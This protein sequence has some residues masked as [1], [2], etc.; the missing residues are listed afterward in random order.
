MRKL[1]LMLALLPMMAIAGNVKSPNGNIELKFSINQEG[2]PVYEMTYKDDQLNGPYTY[3]WEESGKMSRKGVYKNNLRNGKWNEYAQNGKILNSGKYVNDKKEGV[4]VFY[5][6][7]EKK[8]REQNFVHDVPEGKFTEYYDN[9]AKHF[10]GNFKDRL[11]DGKW[12]CWRPDGKLFYSAQFS[13]G[14]KVKELFVAD[15]KE[16]RPF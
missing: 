2:R 1:L 12:S 16:G 10:Q 3:Y 7:H 14:H 11:R 15:P 13:R 5:N 8:I 6:V 4:W 9:G